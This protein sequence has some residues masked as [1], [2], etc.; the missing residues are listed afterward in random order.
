M[1]RNPCIQL[2][3]ALQG[4]GPAT[5]LPRVLWFLLNPL[6]LILAAWLQMWLP[7][8]KTVVLSLSFIQKNWKKFVIL[9]K[10]LV[11]NFVTESFFYQKDVLLDYFIKISEFMPIF[12]IYWRKTNVKFSLPFSFSFFL[13]YSIIISNKTIINVPKMYV[14]QS[15]WKELI[16]SKHVKITVP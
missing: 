9:R 3:A 11:F 10:R 16:F 13:L 8:L 2:P 7:K 5:W 6:T 14:L 12:L 4:S 15:Q 1:A